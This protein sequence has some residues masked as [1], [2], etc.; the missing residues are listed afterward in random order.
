MES[1]NFDKINKIYQELKNEQ[2]SD[3]KFDESVNEFEEIIRRLDNRD[4]WNT[5]NSETSGNVSEQIER[6]SSNDG[7]R[8]NK[9]NSSNSKYSLKDSQGNELSKEQAEFLLNYK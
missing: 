9:T 8:N 7:I 3:F 1:G 6:E 4:L 5:T 2:R